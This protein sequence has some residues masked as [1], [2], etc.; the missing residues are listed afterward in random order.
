MNAPAGTA[1]EA[2]RPVAWACAAVA[3]GVSLHVDRIP[4]WASVT[5]AALIAWRL[6]A[7]PR[8]RWQPGRLARALLA[9]AMAAVVLARFHAQ[10][11]R[12]RHDAARAHGGARSA[13]DPARAIS[14]S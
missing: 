12:R 7:A 5:C 13:R 4:A 9:L 14:W 6:A 11:S 2:L 8:G 3:G 1:R 10:R